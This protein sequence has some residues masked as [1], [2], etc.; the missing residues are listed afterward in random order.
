MLKSTIIAASALIILGLTA[1]PSF[2][3]I[4]IAEA[5]NQRL[6]PVMGFEINR[7]LFT[8]YMN[9]RVYFCCPSCPTEFKQTPD[10]YMAEMRNQGVILENAPA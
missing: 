6:C 4:A 9:Q 5:A 2:S 8:G 1:I 3:P 10:E 7:E